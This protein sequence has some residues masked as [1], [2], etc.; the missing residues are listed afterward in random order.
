[1]AISVP[2]KSRKTEPPDFRRVLMH[3]LLNAKNSGVAGIDKRTS[4]KLKRAAAKK[5]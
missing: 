5:K 1:M 4:D 2:R 3:G